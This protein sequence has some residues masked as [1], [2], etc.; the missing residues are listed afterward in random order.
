[1]DQEFRARKAIK[2]KAAVD[3]SDDIGVV[4]RLLL[5]IFARRVKFGLPSIPKRRAPVR[6]TRCHMVKG[7]H[8]AAHLSLPA[9]QSAL[10]I[11]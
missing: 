2:L 1:M 11:F 7:L 3:F 6:Y 8:L 4:A 5:Q 9:C 10:L